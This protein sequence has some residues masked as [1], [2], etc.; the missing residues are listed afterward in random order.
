MHLLLLT[1]IF[2]APVQADGL[3]RYRAGERLLDQGKTQ[4]A[5]LELRTA[6]REMEALKHEEP[7]LGAILDALGRAQLRAGDYRSAKKYFERA[8]GYWEKGTESRAAALS[9]AG[10][11]YAALGEYA[12]A[13]QSFREALEIMP[14]HA[15]L[16]Q[17]V[18]SV[19]VKQHR[20]EEATT[21]ER[22]A[23]ALGDLAVAAVAW[24]DLA[25]L[26]QAQHKNREAAEMLGRAVVAAGP[27]QG[28]ARMLYNLGTIEWKLGSR[29]QAEAHL[30]QALEEMET[31][32]GPQHPDVGK[33]LDDYSI[34]LY[35]A[36]RRPEAKQ[37]AMRAE[38]IR[39]SF[40]VHTNSNRATVDWRD[41]K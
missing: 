23:L 37:V 39:G 36:G 2:F 32:L 12:R 35:K 19:L 4:E 7:A 27:G 13:E 30:R 40:A 6:L 8:L 25:A 38:A 20:Y 41:L 16:W 21:A 28:R 26:S 31:S 33:I 15:S 34:M 29:Q 3:E 22:N 18:G 1:V 17:L 10:Q 5:L 14:R 11:A 9:N 24:N